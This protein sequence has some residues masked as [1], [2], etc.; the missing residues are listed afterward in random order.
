MSP[1][2]VVVIVGAL[3]PSEVRGITLRQPW[4]S[5]VADLGKDVENR[6]WATP[7]RGLL[8]IHAGLRVERDAVDELGIATDQRLPRGCIIAV[9][10][11][12]DVVDNSP[13]RWARAG[14]FHWLLTDVQRLAD[15]IPLT[16]RLG[17]FRLPDE[18]HKRL[19]GLIDSVTGSH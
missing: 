2:L 13:S 15:P 16:G 11:L 6:T 17:L 4:A 5:A 18:V 19:C 14:H 8:A 9:A 12:S 1:A 3:G 7:Y 10:R